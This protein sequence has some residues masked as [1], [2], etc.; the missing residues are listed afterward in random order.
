MHEKEDDEE[1]DFCVSMYLTYLRFLIPLAVTVIAFDLGGPLVNSGMARLPE[2]KETLAAFG[3][4]WTLMLFLF[5]PLQQVSQLG[6]VLAG[7]AKAKRKIQK[8]VLLVCLSLSVA[9]TLFVFTPIGMW[10]LEDLHRVDRDLG[11]SAR[12]AVMALIPLPII[13]GMTSYHSG[14]L[15]RAHS[16]A[17]ICYAT[18]ANIGVSLL[19][20]FLLLRFESIQSHPIRLPIYVIYMGSMA[21]LTIILFGYRRFARPILAEARAPF[22]SHYR[23]MRFFFPLATVMA[24]Q[25]ISRPIINLFVSRRPDGVT[26]LAVVAVAYSLGSVPYGWLNNLKSLV[27]AFAGWEDSRRSILRFCLVCGVG[28]FFL[29]S[30]L[31]LTP[32]RDYLLLRII[33]LDP[34]IAS[35]CAL[36]LILSAFLPP[37]VLF[38]AYYHG[39]A[40]AEQ[41]TQLLAPSG[42]T[43]IAATI[44]ILVALPQTGLHGAAIGI[45]A[46]L[47]GFIF[48]TIVVVWMVARNT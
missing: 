5:N 29:A 12:S 8:F 16:T 34:E 30:L 27:P 40:M 10:F 28:S 39:I 14:L 23:S 3:L 47:G 11:Q 45:A 21:E 9:L 36:P 31:F 46:L 44:L 18:F 25:G 43:R 6:L 2:S 26:A 22:V 48:E 24:L 38:R 17:P 19:S 1:E 42:P 7:S 37:T 13:I 20:V 35:L 32:L 33:A 15:M 4:A 41:R